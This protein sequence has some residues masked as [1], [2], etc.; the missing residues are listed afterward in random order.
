MTGR[1]SELTLGATLD[2]LDELEFL[3]KSDTSMAATGTNKRRALSVF[4]AFFQTGVTVDQHL[5]VPYGYSGN[6]AVG[7][8]TDRW[9]MT[10]AGTISN[11]AAWVQTPPTGASIRV[12]VNKNGTT[13]FTTQ[14]NRPEIV[15]GA[16]TDLASVP[17]VT[18]FNAGDYF[19]VDIDAIGSGTVGADL[20]LLIEFLEAIS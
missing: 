4:K 18:S 2:D 3:D 6:L 15:A 16:R 20:T 7:A 1:I 17:D 8:G 13:V 9:Y 14:G 12:D 5:Y 11:V 19:T 10:R